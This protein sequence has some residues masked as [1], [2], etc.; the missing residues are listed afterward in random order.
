MEPLY[1]SLTSTA[2]AQGSLSS[3]P[4]CEPPATK[5]VT[6][7]WASTCKPALS[8]IPEPAAEFGD[9]AIAG[10]AA[11][12]HHGST[13]LR[14]P[15]YKSTLVAEGILPLLRGKLGVIHLILGGVATSGV[16][17]GRAT[18]TTDLD[19]DVTVV[20]RPVLGP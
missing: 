16:V 13:S 1:P 18:H 7:H 11:D 5:K 9:L 19:F 17:L 10:A 3:L 12:G 4:L 14:A 8:A 20:E 2:E 6:E 15:G